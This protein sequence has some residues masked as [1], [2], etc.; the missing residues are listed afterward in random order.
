V[1]LQFLAA[2][3]DDLR[4]RDTP[5]STEARP[6]DDCDDSDD[7]ARP[8]DGESQ[9]QTSET[10]GHERDKNNG[11]RPT[12]R[13]RPPTRN[14]LGLAAPLGTNVAGARARAA[15]SETDYR[16]F[17][18][19]YDTVM[20]AEDFCAPDELERLRAVLDNRLGTTRRAAGRL[21][22]RLQRL[23]M[24]LRNNGWDVA[25]EEGVLDTA[26]L[27]DLIVNPLQPPLQ[28]SADRPLSRYGRDTAH[29]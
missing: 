23:L 12:S 10:P 24:A 7:V 13:A 22:H 17:S 27:S 14:D 2:I 16:I 3:G 29:R 21:A 1:V 4:S 11:A 20:R 15:K 25:Q 6:D 18:T 28:A 19:Q 5:Q 26:R 9:A 8:E